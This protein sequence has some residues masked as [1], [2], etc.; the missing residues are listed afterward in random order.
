[1][2]VGRLLAVATQADEYD[3]SLLSS[4]AAEEIL[5]KF[6]E[7]AGDNQLTA[8]VGS[9]NAGQRLV[10]ALLVHARGKLH[11]WDWASAERVLVVDGVVA[12]P[13][14][15]LS[16]MA[17]VK[18][19]GAAAALGAAMLAPRCDVTRPSKARSTPAELR[20]AV[21]LFAA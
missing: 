21:E 15:V 11:L 12:S 5:T 13:V 19:R 14:G 3:R 8:V 6:V 7:L 4:P 9:G 10:G 20:P 1:M 18:R 2:E 17:L 16:T